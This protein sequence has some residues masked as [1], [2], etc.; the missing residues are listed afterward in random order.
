MIRFIETN[1]R[2]PTIDT[3]ARISRAFKIPLNQLVIE[4]EGKLKL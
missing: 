3:I 4:A 2:I 1:G